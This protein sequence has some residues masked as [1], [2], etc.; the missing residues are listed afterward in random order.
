M[1][2]VKSLDFDGIAFWL[3]D[4]TSYAYTVEASLVSLI[5]SFYTIC[6]T[7]LSLVSSISL[8]SYNA[9]LFAFSSL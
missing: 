8:P 6:E 5:S 7:A 2:C 9:Y 3:A 4:V 1:L